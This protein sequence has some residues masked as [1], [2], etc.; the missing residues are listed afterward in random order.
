MA[1]DDT[2]D[3]S[4][5]DSGL[6]NCFWC[7]CLHPGE[8]PLSV[9]GACTARYATL[10]MLEMSGSYPL[11]EDGVDAVLSQK[12]AGNYALGYLDD[13]DFRVFYV[14]RSD[15]D[16]KQR[17]HDWIGMPSRFD[18][19]S[20]VATAPWQL[21]T[22]GRSRADL[23]ARD[24]EAWGDGYTRFAYSYSPS[25]QEAYAQEWRNY[26]AFGGDRAL[27]NPVQP[28]QLAA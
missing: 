14:G 7:E 25:P 16:V 26:D 10:R 1:D 19:H 27:D 2:R 5:P 24:P 22:G 6:V 15:S 18:R 3:R 8:H 9:C 11:T 28:V 20:S 13:G 17:L 12:S 23:R 21:R 4:L